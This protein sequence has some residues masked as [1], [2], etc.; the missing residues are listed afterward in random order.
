VP[1]PEDGIVPSKVT[2]VSPLQLL[3]ALF[4]ILST[5][6]GMVILLRLSQ[7]AKTDGLMLSTVPG[8]IMPGRLMQTAKAAP[9]ILIRLGGIFMLTRLPHNLKAR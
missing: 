8:M 5:L 4:P 6:S 1:K 7:E 2:L 3:K 9:P